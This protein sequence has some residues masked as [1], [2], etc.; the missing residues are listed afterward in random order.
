MGDKVTRPAKSADLTRARFLQQALERGTPTLSHPESQAAAATK[1]APVFTEEDPVFNFDS[2]EV[3]KAYLEQLVECAPEAITILNQQHQILRLNAEFTRM[4]GFAPE[5]ALGRRIDILIVPPDR[6]SE[7]RWIAD[8]LSQGRKV[9]LETKRQRKD[10]SLVDVF[11]SSAP[12]IVGGKQVAACVLYRD[13][14]EQKRAEA[15]S[16]A[17]YRIAEKTSSAEDLQQFYA[18]SPN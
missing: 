17:L 10:G 9:T 16:S 6:N 4:F 13:I 8:S 2:P 1:Q 7:T 14:S 11:L 18:S 12:V 15:L 3:E 5:E